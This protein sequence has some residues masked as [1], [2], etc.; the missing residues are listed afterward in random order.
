M[1]PLLSSRSVRKSP[2]MSHSIVVRILLLCL[3]IRIFASKMV[4]NAI[5]SY[6]KVLKKMILFGSFQTLCLFRIIFK[7]LSGHKNNLDSCTSEANGAN[8]KVL[9]IFNIWSHVIFLS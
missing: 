9:L 1:E 6:S 2:K 8:C 7:F 4:K 3:N 5:K